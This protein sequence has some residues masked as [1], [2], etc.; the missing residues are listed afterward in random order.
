MPVTE[1]LSAG[2]SRWRRWGFAAASLVVHAGLLVA[3]VAGTNQRETAIVEPEEEEEI[4][5]VDISRVAP[6]PPPSAA[7]VQQQ[8]EPTP[9]T[10][11]PE[12]RPQPR[13]QPRT[14]A[15]A[16]DIIDPVDSLPDQPLGETPPAPRLERSVEPQVSGSAGGQAGGVAGGVEGGQQGG[17]IG[18]VVGGQGEEVPDPDGTYI[19][20]VVDRKAELSNRNALPRLMQRLYPD[21]L[22][23]A[24]IGGRVIVQ[25]V[26][27]T[28][29][30]VDMSTVKILS[31]SHDGFEDATRK[32]IREFRFKPARMGDRKVRM[33]TQL[34]II[35]E[36]RR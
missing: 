36:V 4:T 3:L 10:P 30:R 9:R 7:P 1:K 27:D 34:P 23:D 5:F 2:R 31:A 11:Q 22:R 35:W 13:P 19:A 15:R 26:V 33:L 29:G 32:A 12:T 8:P 20:A 25:F 14:P 6:P 16:A 28:N 21:V 17:K 24:G 18:G